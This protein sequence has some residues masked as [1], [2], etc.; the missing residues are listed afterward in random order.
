M[1]AYGGSGRAAPVG[2]TPT[3]APSHTRAPARSARPRRVLS[4]RTA[5]ARGSR[6][7]RT[8][9]R[10]ST[11]PSANGTIPRTRMR[12]TL[13]PLAA[14]S[15]EEDAVGSAIRATGARRRAS[16]G[17]P[18]SRARAERAV[19]HGLR[20]PVPGGRGRIGRD[21]HRRD[22]VAE[23]PALLACGERNAEIEKL[24]RQ[25]GEVGRRPGLLR[26]S[27]RR[28]THERSRGRDGAVARY[29]DPRLPAPAEAV[30]HDDRDRGLR[31]GRRRPRSARTGA[32]V[33]SARRS[34]PAR[35]CAREPAR[36]PCQEARSPRRARAVRRYRTHCRRA[37]APRLRCR[38]E[39]RR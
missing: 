17:G 25:A 36:R 15:E 10:R 12:R 9:T 28:S 30:E 24:R 21:G 34:R 4:A 6:R 35:A 26:D 33:C 7:R 11:R 23:K 32:S 16:R 14:R 18:R 39:Q 37:A 20:D 2:N 19:E 31:E 29:R 5:G 3:R 38:D 27:R 1:S 13:Q 8:R 22:V